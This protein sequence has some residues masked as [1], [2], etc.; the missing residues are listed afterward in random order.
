MKDETLLALVAIIYLTIIEIVN[1][2]TQGHDAI[3][4]TSIASIIIFLATRHW[5][6]GR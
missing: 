1:H 3:L 6:R 5:Y 2:I 4:H